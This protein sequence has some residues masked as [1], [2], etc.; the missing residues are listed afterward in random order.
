MEDARQRV[1][2]GARVCDAVL[3]SLRGQVGPGAVGR[4]AEVDEIG[5]VVV[6]YQDVRRLDV[7][8]HQSD[9]V[10]GMQGRGDLLND[11]DRA[12][13][14][15]RPAP[16]SWF[17]PRP[18]ISRIVKYSRPS[19]SP[20]SWIGTICGSSSPAAAR[21]SCRNR[22]SKTSSSAQF[23]GSIFKATTRSMA[24]SKARHTSPMPPRPSNS[25]NR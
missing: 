9:F 16:R 8:M 15:Q 10:A 14:R 6:G 4:D 7:A 23:A 25:T 2:I 13:R 11:P 3:E 19:I 5:E 24:V 18:L 12:G 17:K 1:D 21:T 22:V 20:K